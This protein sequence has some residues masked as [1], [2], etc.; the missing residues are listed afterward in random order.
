MEEAVPPT[1]SFF[2]VESPKLIMLQEERRGVK[3]GNLD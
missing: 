3:T 2:L 1:S